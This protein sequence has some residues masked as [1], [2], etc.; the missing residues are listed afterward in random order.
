[1]KISGIGGEFAFIKRVAGVTCDDPAVVRGV[2]DD[3]AVLEYTH[4]NYLLVT[5]DMLVEN[6]H[7]SLAWCTPY[8]IG[9]KLM[10]VNVSDI[11]AMGGAPR[12]AFISLALTP[13]TQ[14]EFMDEFYRGLYDSA[15]MHGVTLAGGDTTHGALLAFNLALVGE[16]AKDLVR[17]RSGAVPGDLICV[18][19]TLGKS[20][21]GLQLLMKG[22]DGYVEGYCEPRSRLVWEGKAVARRAHAMIDVSDGLGSEVRHI[23]EESGVGGRIDWDK[24]PLSRDTLEA[25]RMANGDPFLYALYGGED[26]ELLFTVPAGEIPELQKEFSDFTVVGEVLHE[27]DGVFILKRG[28]KLAVKT[29]YDHFV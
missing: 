2:G 25:A 24:I 16:A 27:D 17:Y 12:W 8:Q 21:A 22:M 3:C 23:C 28:R 20:E 29:G 6:S 11:V 13:D 14:V 4:D 15:R 26:Y 19:G 7:F 1:M 5:T 10:E 18:T 9:K